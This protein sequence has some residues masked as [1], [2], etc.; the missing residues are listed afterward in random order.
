[1][2]HL[3][4]GKRRVMLAFAL[5][6][7]VMSLAAVALASEIT[8]TAEIEGTTVTTVT[9]AQGDST[10]FNVHADA[11]GAVQCQSTSTAKADTAYAVNDSGIVSS[12]TPSTAMTWND[13]GTTQGGGMSPNCGTT[14]N[15]QTRAAAVTASANAPV[16]TYTNV[17]V[18]FT[19]I[20]TVGTGTGSA[21][22]SD[23]TLSTITVVVVAGSVNQAPTTPGTPGATSSV[24]EGQFTLNWTASTD[25]DNDPITYRLEHKD[26]N[27]AGYSLVTGAGSLSTNSFTF[28]SS[29]PEG[30]GT[31]T[32]QV[33]AS[34]GT[35]T[36]AFSAASNTVKVDQHAPTTPTATPD[37][38][39]DYSGGG[40]WFL[41]SVTVSYSGSTDPNLQDGSAG[42]DNITYSA[43]DVLNS[44]GANAYS[45][46]ATDAAGNESAAASGSLNVDVNKPIVQVTC[47]SGPVTQNSSQTASYTAS[48][49]GE[50]G[51]AS[52]AS[53]TVALDTSQV[54][55]YTATVPA[56][57]AV[58]NVGR[59]SAAATC[60]YSVVYNW[61]GFFR[62]VDNPEVLNT[63]K[64]GSAIP[65]KFSLAGDQ[66]LDILAADYPTSNKINCLNSADMDSI[67]ET[68]TAGGSTLKYDATADQY[69]YV[70]K[71][72][73]SWAGKCRQL[74]V[75]L[76]DGTSHVAN[77]KLMK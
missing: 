3:I 62:P 28:G 26:A 12:G 70:W 52:G 13:N 58:D 18:K 51:I 22:L 25:S 66:G 15:P 40:G 31:W 56:G 11:T 69:V 57:T 30:E 74:N 37:R 76:D 35:A 61:T 45:G 39:P 67:E 65:V 23:A 49:P 4:H 7:G 42:S 2:K 41:G 68:M 33:Q 34:D 44:S 14:S 19:E 38:S 1:M 59:G 55:T 6:L 73:K 17:P 64:A 72:D 43:A 10:S 54:G 48:D 50:S 29:N 27:D 16:G 8:A 46:T 47:P 71:T 75:T 36:S 5:A 53:G 63:V 77:F 60:Q 32:Y 24:N 21:K 20:S 9:V